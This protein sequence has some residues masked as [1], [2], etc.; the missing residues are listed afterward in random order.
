[1][2]RKPPFSPPDVNERVANGII[3]QT[4]RYQLITPLFGGG[5]TPGEADPVTVIRGTEVRGHLRFWW[6]ACRAAKFSRMED[7]KKEENNIWGSTETPSVVNITVEIISSNTIKREPA[8]EVIK[9][10]V[11]GK[12]K[13]RIKPSPKIA[14]YAAFPL[15]PEKHE[16]RHVGW[17][18]EEIA[19]DVKFALNLTYPSQVAN[20]IEAALWAW[21]T[22]GGIGARTR[23]G[24][25]ALQCTEI[26]GRVVNP[27]GKQD[28]K[29]YIR[30]QLSKHVILGKSKLRGVPGLDQNMRLELIQTP[31]DAIGVW[32]LIINK[33][34]EFR[35]EN[36]RYENKYGLSMWPEANEIRRYFGK[37]AKLPDYVD[38]STLVRKF[39]RAKFGLPIVFHMPH[40]GD[41][42][43][44]LH[45]SEMEPGKW[46]DRL[47]SPLI[48][49]PVACS[50][51]AVGLAAILEWH[52]LRPDD[53]SYTPPGGLI[54]KDA[55]GNPRVE[56]N[57]TDAE[58]ENIPPLKGEPDIFKAFLN[59]LKEQEK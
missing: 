11:R 22:F 16:Q 40:D 2:S 5:V 6:R 13:I 53:E 1:M 32:K 35:Q 56:S 20:D 59:S 17:K 30:E 39:P 19:Y 57:L 29:K 42:T 18:S 12:D 3:T 9:E 24:F 14:S 34:Q 28:Y 31:L 33:L 45:G 27:P 21:E 38:E 15:L 48:L 23:R 47:A 41:K 7:L 46:Y 25:G 55:P 50:D 8:F 36:A 58:A 10:V 43:V 49:R 37:P 4:R 52:P 51:G 26:G 44:M 54:L